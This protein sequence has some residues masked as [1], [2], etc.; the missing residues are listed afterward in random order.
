MLERHPRRNSHLDLLMPVLPLHDR[1]LLP[2]S[3]VGVRIRRPSDGLM[4]DILHRREGDD[5]FLTWLCGTLDAPVCLGPSVGGDHDDVPLDDLMR[6]RLSL[7]LLIMHLLHLYL[8]LLML[9]L[10]VDH[11][12]LLMLLK[13]LLLLLVLPSLSGILKLHLRMAGMYHRDARLSVCLS[14]VGHDRWETML[15]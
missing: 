6:L 14:G 1:H 5:V 3:L 11:L 10:L 4:L 7:L 13:L 12:L 8:L 9:L 15:S 2:R